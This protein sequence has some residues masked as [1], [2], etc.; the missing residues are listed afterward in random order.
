MSFDGGMSA[1]VTVA[2]T[3]HLETG[4]E[5]EM[6]S[7][8]AAGISLAEKFPGFLGGGWVRPDLGSD[9]WHMLYRFADPD[10]LEVWENSSQREWW[11]ASAAGLGVVEARVERRTGIEGWF[12]DPMTTEVD[13][14][15]PGVPAPPRW[16]QACTIFLVFLPLS[17]LANWIARETLS[18]MALPLRVLIVTLV[19]T[20]VMTYAGLPWITR[21]LHWWLHGRPA[22]WRR[23]R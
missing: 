2:I 22:P 5:D 19:L 14:V 12:D 11:K 17:L 16:K 7:W 13:D 9:T 1:P 3:R 15:R 4:H 23:V 21:T 20:P 6:V 8:F 18:T 10:S